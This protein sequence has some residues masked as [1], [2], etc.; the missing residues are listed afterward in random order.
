MTQND[1]EQVYIT[2]KSTLYTLSTPGVQFLICFT[3]RPDVFKVQGCQKLE[4]LGCT[5]RLESELEHLTVKSTMYRCTLCTCPRG[6]NFTYVSLYDHPFSRYCAFYNSQK[7]TANKLSKLSNFTI[8][9]TTLIAIL[10]RGTYDC[11]GVNLIF[12]FRGENKRSMDLGALLDNCSWYDN[13]NFLQTCIKNTLLQTKSIEI[14]TLTQ[15]LTM[16]VSILDH[17]QHLNFDLSSSVKVKCD[18]GI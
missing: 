1:L 4:I 18:G 12:H 13:G 2:V 10:I 11:G 3:L 5:Q 14:L 8:L 15:Y 6:P 17:F 7:L 16:R 9:L